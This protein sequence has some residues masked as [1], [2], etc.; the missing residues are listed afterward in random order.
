[1]MTA[2]WGAYSV[3]ALHVALSLT[4]PDIF[5]SDPGVA[6]SPDLTQLCSAAATPSQVRRASMATRATTSSKLGGRSVP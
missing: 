3:L 1:M 4:M 6:I 2:T 5:P